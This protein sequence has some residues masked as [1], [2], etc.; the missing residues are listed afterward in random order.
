VRQVLTQQTTWPFEVIA[1]DSSSTDGTWEFLESLPIARIRI[2]PKDFNHG[3]TRNLGATHARGDFLVFLVQDAIPADAY[4]LQNLVSAAELPGVVGAYSRQVPRAE[5]RLTTKY[6]TIG[7]TPGEATRQWKSLPAGVHLAD[8]SPAEQFR[9]AVFQDNSSCIRRSFF[10]QQPFRVL[11]YGEDVDWGRRAIESGHALIY[12]PTS[13]V[14]HSHDRSPLYALKRAYADHYQCAEL[15][16]YVMLRS[17]AVAVRSAVWQTL[18]AWR[19]I[20]HQGVCAHERLVEAAMAP[21]YLGAV[22]L[23]QYLGPRMF[24]TGLQRPWMIM[25]DRKLR[26]GV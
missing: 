12:E 10:D 14:D 7:T 16:D 25:L 1:I 6:M 4:W 21:V 20:L 23:G 8:L 19:Y 11:P 15:F 26:A 17:L 22:A 2:D 18:N 24:R 9:L 13:V 5:S 3:G